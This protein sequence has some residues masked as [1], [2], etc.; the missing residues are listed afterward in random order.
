VNKSKRI[1]VVGAE[2][3]DDAFGEFIYAGAHV[4][5]APDPKK[6]PIDQLLD[7][8]VDAIMNDIS[9]GPTFKRLESDPR[10]KHLW[11]DYMAEDYKLYQEMGI[12]TPAHLLVMSK[13]LD[14]QYPDLAGKLYRAFEDAKKIAYQDIAN[15][16]GSFSVVYLR[17]RLEEQEEKFGDPFKY[18]VTGAKAD[19]DA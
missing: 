12:F 18:G 7:G 6:S 10:V 19:I 3:L 13:K 17:E 5:M 14:Q 9:D 2:N 1:W 11:V 15:D 8:D 4:E 16:R